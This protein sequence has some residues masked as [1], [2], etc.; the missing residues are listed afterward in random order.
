MASQPNQPT[1]ELGRL[2]VLSST[3]GLR[4]SPL[5]LGGSSIGEKWNRMRG[6]MDK[7]KAFKL[8]DAFVD[9]GGNGIDTSNDYQE[10]QSEVWIGEWMS[11]RGN[12]DQLVVST[13]FTSNYLRS[14]LPRSKT[15]NYAGNHRRSMY[16]SVR[17]SLTKLQTSYL[18]ILYLHWWDYTTSVEEIM[19][20]LHLLVQQGKVMYLGISDTPAWV[21]SAANTYARAHGKTPFSVYQGQWNILRRDFK[22]DIVPMARYY[23]MALAPWGVLGSGKFRTRKVVEE[24]EKAGEPIC[25]SRGGQSEEDIAVSEVLAKVAAEHGIES[26]TA[27]ALAYILR[28]SADLGVRNIFPIVGGR[29][30]ENLHDNIQALSIRLTDAQIQLLEDV[31][32][33][34]IGWPNTFIGKDPKVTGT[35]QSMLASTGYFAFP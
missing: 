33:F 13:K 34:D 1:T 35:A 3:S 2:R 11:E 28:K 8:L 9:A 27:I 4:V 23:G 15:A 12:R 31:K 20:S 5:A 16:V 30:V 29:K 14:E 10:G 7:D 25:P 6:A 24:R 19:D 22:R 17:D 26:V 18:D 32:T 21:V